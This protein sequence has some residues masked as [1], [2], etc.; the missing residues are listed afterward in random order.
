MILAAN[1]SD[2]DGAKENISKK[3]KEYYPN[4][5]V[6]PCSADSELALREAAKSEMIKYIPGRK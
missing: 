4:L 5:L 2:M 1:K 6:V 3:L